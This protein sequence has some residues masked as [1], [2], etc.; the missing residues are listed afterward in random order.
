L[1]AL[2]TVG[3]AQAQSSVTVY[4]IIDTGYQVQ[5]RVGMLNNVNEK[6]SA[7][8][9]NAQSSSRLGVR[10]VEDLGGGTRAEFVA[11][12][13]LR[14]NNSSFSGSS[15]D[16][17]NSTF[18]NR[19]TFLALEDAKLGRILAGRTLTSTFQ[20]IAM[21]S[22]GGMNNTIGS[23]TYVGGLSTTDLLD[24]PFYGN[25]AFVIRSSESLAYTTPSLAGLKATVG[26]AR[27]LKDATNQTSGVTTTTD[28]ANSNSIRLEYVSGPLS[29]AANQT[30]HK[31]N[32]A[33]AGTAATSFGAMGLAAAADSGKRFN[34]EQQET[35]FGAA[36]RL[37]KATLFANHLT[38]KVKGTVDGTALTNNP[39]R[40]AWEIGV[41]A[42]IAGKVSGWA[43]Y[44]QGTTN[45]TSAANIR[46]ATA[47]KFD[48]D[49]H[50]VGLEYGFSKRTNA[51]AI[52]G[53]ANA[54]K[55][56][57]TKAEATAYAVGVRHQF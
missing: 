3:A 27:N 13:G 17:N 56:A 22:A 25:N 45:L 30:K 28:S 46:S 29:L 54:D 55:T 15:N 35:A 2:A 52:Y 16:I 12:F 7:V 41:R 33:T 36:Y 42:P 26:I 43:S 32:V 18:D 19:Q 53:K 5:D 14:V 6:T 24:T 47:Q 8:G 57:T 44:G 31:L 49:A 38:T 34:M 48:F 9:A 10:G 4:G 40:K 1:A 23:T 39:E 50:Q 21:S 51:Y 20:T 37:P 11:E